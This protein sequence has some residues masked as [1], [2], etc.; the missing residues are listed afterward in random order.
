MIQSRQ[1]AIS[2]FQ[3]RLKERKIKMAGTRRPLI[4]GNWK[5]NGLLTDSTD[6]LRN[7]ILSISTIVEPSFDLLVS[8]PT[9][10]LTNIS[11]MIKE[12]GIFLCGQDCHPEKFGAYTG[13][14]SAVMLADAGCSHVIVGHSERR[15]FYSETNELVRKKATVAIEAGLTPIICIGETEEERKAGNTNDVILKQ[16]SAS[17]PPKSI[18]ENIIVAYEPVWAIGTGL[19]PNKEDVQDTHSLIR[20]N[21]SKIISPAFAEQ[22]RLLY[23]GSVKPNNARQFFKLPDVDGALV[24]GAS[25]KWRDFMAIAES[26]A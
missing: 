14:I 25:L 23:G 3:P 16:L 4:A 17:L 6:R 22:I 13:D 26:C 1:Y 12:S 10:L 5:M 11:D 19:I 20:A 7:I 9:T 21:I 18:L 24:G 2:K 15:I 8:P